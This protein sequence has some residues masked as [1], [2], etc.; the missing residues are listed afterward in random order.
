[1]KGE[2]FLSKSYCTNRVCTKT[3]RMYKNQIA[4]FTSCFLCR[5]AW[6]LYKSD[7]NTFYFLSPCLF[8]RVRHDLDVRY[9]ERNNNVK[10]YGKN[11]CTIV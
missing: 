10:E 6:L 1:M 2:V 9:L 11:L 7:R 3:K 4:L 8:M 5:E